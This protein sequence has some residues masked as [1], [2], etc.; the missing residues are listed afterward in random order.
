[1]ASGSASPYGWTPALLL[2][3]A[4]DHSGASEPTLHL[5]TDLYQGNAQRGASAT[6]REFPGVPLRLRLSADV[7]AAASSAAADSASEVPVSSPV[8][9]SGRGVVYTDRLIGEEFDPQRAAREESAFYRRSPINYMFRARSPMIVF[10]GR[11]DRV[12]PPSV[13]EEIVAALRRNGIQH[14]YV[15]YENEG[16]GF[17]ASDTNIDALTRETAFYARVLEMQ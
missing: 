9:A 10:Q 17:R 14:E 2:L 16:H 12:V 5:S 15:E 8:A 1:M 6:R 3:A 11:Q 4:M 13:A 7:A